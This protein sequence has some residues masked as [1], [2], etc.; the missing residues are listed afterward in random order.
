MKCTILLLTI[1]TS[2]ASCWA[3]QKSIPE[4]QA[5]KEK[6]LNEKSPFEKIVARELPATIVYENDFVIA[7]IPLKP[8]AAV[9]YLIVPKKRIN[10]VNDATDADI[11][12]LGHMFLAA[13]EVA[14]KFGVAETGYRLAINTNRD[15]GQ[16]EFHL[17]MHLLGGEFL[18]KMSGN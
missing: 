15:A 18:G 10:T 12:A 6:K 3:Q 8:Q 13:K 9:H 14:K 1:L 5:M 11:T 17:H 4:Y 7:F 16:S 2:S